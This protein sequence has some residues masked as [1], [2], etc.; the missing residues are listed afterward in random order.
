MRETSQSSLSC[1]ASPGE[2]RSRLR[3]G[4]LSLP[5][6][7]VAVPGGRIMHL[8][9]GRSEQTEGTPRRSPCQGYGGLC[10][11]A[12]RCSGRAIE[13]SKRAVR[14]RTQ[15]RSSAPGSAPGWIEAAADYTVEL[16]AG[17]TVLELDIPSLLEAA[18]ETFEEEI[19]EALERLS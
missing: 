14:M 16:K 12:A 11:A 6:C 13:G 1:P 15:G 18:P 2:S 5:R 10:G 3:L 7:I 8:S 4:I 17:S 9:G 19:Q